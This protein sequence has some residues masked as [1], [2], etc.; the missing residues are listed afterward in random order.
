MTILILKI[1]LAYA[2]AIPTAYAIGTT[3]GIVGLLLSACV[4]CLIGYGVSVLVDS[5]IRELRQET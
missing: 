5:A 1:F 2:L 3:F 4:G